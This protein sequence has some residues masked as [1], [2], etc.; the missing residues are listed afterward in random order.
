MVAGWLRDRWEAPWHSV[1]CYSRVL[2]TASGTCMHT[3]THRRGHLLERR[4]QRLLRAHCSCVYLHTIPRTRGNPLARDGVGTLSPL[5]VPAAVVPLPG[6]VQ[7]RDASPWRGNI[8]TLSCLSVPRPTP[9]EIQPASLS[10]TTSSMSFN[11]IKALKRKGKHGTSLALVI[12]PLWA[13]LPLA[14]LS[15]PPS[16]LAPSPT[17][18]PFLPSSPGIWCCFY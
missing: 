9:S 13:H 1:L 17:S 6:P 18:A 4:D 8:P 16:P 3:R 10:V 7:T 5:N 11:V 14:W 12:L 15:C 2:L